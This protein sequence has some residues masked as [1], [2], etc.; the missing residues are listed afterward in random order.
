M[1]NKMYVVRVRQTTVFYN[2]VERAGSGHF[3]ITGGFAIELV[4]MYNMMQACYK[5]PHRRFQR[6][7]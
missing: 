4:Y 2:C 3:C 5:L 7:I 6:R 1:Y